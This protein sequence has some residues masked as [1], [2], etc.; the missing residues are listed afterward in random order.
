MVD[1]NVVLVSGVQQSDSVIHLFQILFA[2]RL[3]QNTEYS[4]L[5]YIVGPCLLV[6]LSLKGKKK[7]LCSSKFKVVILKCLLFWLI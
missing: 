1:L 7:T 4:S 2:Y 6:L 5:C 3:L